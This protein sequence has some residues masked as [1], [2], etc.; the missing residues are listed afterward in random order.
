MRRQFNILNGQE[1]I[2]RKRAMDQ[3]H[4]YVNENKIDFESVGSQKIMQEF[5]KALLVC[6]TD[7]SEKIRETSVKIVQELISR[8]D[9]MNVF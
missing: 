5:C 7:Q 8:C 4:S 3:I 9:D 1:L 2:E 6:F